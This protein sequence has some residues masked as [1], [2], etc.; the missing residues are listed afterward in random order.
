[1]SRPS[2]AELS[3]IFDEI[4]KIDYKKVSNKHVSGAT[5]IKEG[6]Q[7]TIKYKGAVML[8]ERNEKDKDIFF[9]TRITNNYGF[10][11]ESIDFETAQEQDM[12]YLFSEWVD[13]G[14]PSAQEIASVTGKEFSGTIKEIRK[15]LKYRI[16]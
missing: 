8:V 11:V 12:V 1:M 7:M 4:T 13:A 9:Q 15:Y 16:N 10:T 5:V 2:D 3:A 6:N 14:F